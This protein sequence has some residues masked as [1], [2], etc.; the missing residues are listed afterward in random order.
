[1]ICVCGLTDKSALKTHML[2]D[3]HVGIVCVVIRQVWMKETIFKK[4]L[5]ILALEY[6][7]NRTKTHYP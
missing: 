7:I 1:M 2:P 5:T 6:C 4:D 3:L